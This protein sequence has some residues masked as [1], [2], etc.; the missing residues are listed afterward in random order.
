MGGGSAVVS[1]VPPSLA[2]AV[3]TATIVSTIEDTGHREG[4]FYGFL[5]SDGFAEHRG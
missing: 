2:Q 3:L 1:T 4:L 5:N